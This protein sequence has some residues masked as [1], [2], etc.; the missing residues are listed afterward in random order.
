[1]AGDLPFE[2]RLVVLDEGVAGLAAPA[3]VPQPG[4]RVLHV[5]GDRVRVVAPSLDATANVAAAPQ[6]E[7]SADV[8]AGLSESEQL[9]VAALLLRRSDEYVEAKAQRP[10]QGEE[11]D[12]DYGCTEVSPMAAA[13]EAGAPVPPG[14]PTSSFLEGR[15]A[16]GVIIV[17]G[18]TADL[19]FS[20]AEQ[21]KVVAEVQNGLSYLATAN[22]AAGVSFSYD[23]RVVRINVAADPNDPDLEGRWRNPAMAA[24]GSP[25]NW[26]SVDR[27]VRDIR[28]RLDTRWGYCAFFVKYP[29]TWFA[30]A[31]IGG[32][33]LAMQYSN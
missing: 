22:P 14:T 7:V 9:G 4:G 24:L 17:E 10:R 15:V 20:A 26:A 6:P 3:A 27:Y 25:A 31:S 18:P 32:P 21:A 5:Y 13:E 29:Q 2:E 16:V 12:M 1:M 33:R 11:W 23:I 30:Y 19:Q 28:T 8:L